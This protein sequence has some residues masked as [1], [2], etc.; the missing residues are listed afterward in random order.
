METSLALAR[1]DTRFHCGEG[2][3]PLLYLLPPCLILLAIDI[4]LNSSRRLKELTGPSEIPSEPSIPA[5]Q[6]H[7]QP[8]LRLASK[9]QQVVSDFRAFERQTLNQDAVSSSRNLHNLSLELSP[10]RTLSRSCS[11]STLDRRRSDRRHL[12]A[13]AVKQDSPVS[14]AFTTFCENLLQ[15]NEAKKQNGKVKTPSHRSSRKAR[16]SGA[17]KS[18]CDELL[19]ANKVWKQ[20]KEIDELKEDRERM[21]RARVRV[22]TRAAEKM[23]LDVQTDRMV[24]EFVKD[25]LEEAHSDRQAVLDLRQEHE[26][27]VREMME[28]WAKERISMRR[29]IE[30]MRAALEAKSLEQEISND[31]EDRL[32][33]N[34]FLREEVSEDDN[35]QY[36]EVGYT[37]EDDMTMLSSSSTCVET[38]SPPPSK[39]NFRNWDAS[40][41]KRAYSECGSPSLRRKVDPSHFVG[42]SFNPLFFGDRVGGGSPQLQS[43]PLKNRMDSISSPTNSTR[44]RKDSY[45]RPTPLRNTWRV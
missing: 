26:K 8:L 27:D 3:A 40:V 31:L 6:Y 21:K 4:A 5:D 25:V 35:A 18:F 16:E 10:C 22:V 24:E 2:S 11:D 34:A 14:P 1:L 19:L 13:R 42:F 44:P 37:S 17:F 20:Q 33:E 30:R 45:P 15:A 12:A 32:F 36:I 41:R 9:A 7:Q 28:V 23:V 38:P 39:A 29:E 43:F